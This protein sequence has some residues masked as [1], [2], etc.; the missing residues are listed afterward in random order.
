MSTKPSL[1]NLNGE[2]VMG[3]EGFPLCFCCC[4]FGFL[5]W[6][7]LAGGFWDVV[8]NDWEIWERRLLDCLYIL[9]SFFSMVL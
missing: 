3:R 2:L 5:C 7:V 9:F 1:Q 6:F 8:E 4:C